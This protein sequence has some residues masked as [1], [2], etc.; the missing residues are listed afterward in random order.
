[1]FIIQV[2]SSFITSILVSK[3]TFE[4]MR[5]CCCCKSPIKGIYDGYK[6]VDNTVDKYRH[7]FKVIDGRSTVSVYIEDTPKVD[8]VEGYTYNLYC[9]KGD[10]KGYVR[11][12]H[13]VTL[14]ELLIILFWLLLSLILLEFG[15]GLIIINLHVNNVIAIIILS[16][17]LIIQVI[18]DVIDS[19]K[20]GL[21]DVKFKI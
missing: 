4:H 11:Y 7:F 2:I 10:L 5:V 15:L 14:R 12:S 19:A 17:A 18:K 8:F 13:K 1:M 3:L 20:V 9:C 6:R 16:V 21:F